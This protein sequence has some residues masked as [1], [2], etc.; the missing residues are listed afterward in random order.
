MAEVFL[1]FD[2]NYV[3]RHEDMM[4]PTKDLPRDGQALQAGNYLLISSL[5]VGCL[6]LQI[7]ALVKDRLKPTVK[8]P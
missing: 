7:R 3:L 4:D 2:S 1:F 6:I 5:R 8:F